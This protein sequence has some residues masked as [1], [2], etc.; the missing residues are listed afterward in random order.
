MPPTTPT[1]GP[2]EIVTY[3]YNDH[4]GGEAFHK[5]RQAEWLAQTLT[6]AGTAPV[7]PR[8]G[9]KTGSLEAL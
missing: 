2:K 6:S 8:R 1:A 4:E 9:V 3:P 5:A 7:H